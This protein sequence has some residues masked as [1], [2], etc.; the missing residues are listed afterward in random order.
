[1]TKVFKIQFKTKNPMKY[2]TFLNMETLKRPHLINVNLK[3]YYFANDGK[4]E[5]PK[6]NKMLRVSEK[7]IIYNKR[8]EF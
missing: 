6:L 4:D 8:L 7:I 5:I 2:S 1:M 3:K